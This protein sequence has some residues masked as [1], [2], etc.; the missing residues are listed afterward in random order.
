[1]GAAVAEQLEL[2]PGD[3]LVSSPENL[4]DLAGIYPL[5]M[6]VVGVLGR[7]H[8]SDDLAVFVDVKTAWIIQGLGHGHQDLERVT[9]PQSILGRSD[10]SITASAKLF[11]Y[12]EITP[13]NLDSFHFHGDLSGYPLTAVVVEPYD[14]KSGTILQGRYIGDD[15]TEQ[16]IRPRDVVDELLA[17]IFRIKNLLDTVIALV[18]LATLL[19][20]I[21][22]F[23]LSIRLRA[24]EMET[25]FRLGCRRATM[26][27][28]VGAEIV[29]IV[30]AGAVGGLLGMAVLQQFASELVR[31]LIIR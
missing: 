18:A 13:D 5:K 24:R 28:L 27:R 7:S 10:S 9:D 29:T 21:L 17:N 1:V 31:S 3:D 15:A 20:M 30:I 26:V 4:F 23:A 12:T 11:H 2:K 19:A 25:I 14:E 6:R 22:V 16:I 8:S